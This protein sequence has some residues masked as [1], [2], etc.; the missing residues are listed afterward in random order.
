MIQVGVGQGKCAHMVRSTKSRKKLQAAWLE[1]YLSPHGPN[2]GLVVFP[3]RVAVAFCSRLDDRREATL[4]IPIALMLLNRI[5]LL[6]YLYP[7]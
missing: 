4:V 6:Y 5:N 7:A 2:S 3:K 1:K